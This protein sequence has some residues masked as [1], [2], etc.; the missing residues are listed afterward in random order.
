MT[1]GGSSQTLCSTHSR[2][3]ACN[4]T[5]AATDSASGSGKAGSSTGDGG[6]T[7]GDG[8]WAAW[9]ASGSLEDMYLKL[10]EYPETLGPRIDAMDMG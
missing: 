9:V 10:G 3:I 5:A 7:S 1:A 4:T 2:L 6:L 8:T